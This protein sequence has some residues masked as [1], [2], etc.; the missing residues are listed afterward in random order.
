MTF[1]TS[2][3]GGPN[4]WLKYASSQHNGCPIMDLTPNRK[5]CDFVAISDR[6]IPRAAAQV[7][8]CLA[9]PV[10]HPRSICL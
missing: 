10:G 2:N 5:K 1:L 4:L 9:V 3:R 8:Q 7:A 6:N